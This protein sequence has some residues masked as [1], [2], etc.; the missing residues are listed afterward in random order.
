MNRSERGF[1][2]ILV[3][4]SLVLL[5]S[6]ATGFSLAV[7]HQTRLAADL[8]A[9]ARAEAAA[10]AAL[11]TAMLAVAAT[12]GEARWR[13]DGRE[14]EIPWPDAKITVRVQSESGRIDINTA[15]PEL[16][17]GL[18]TRLFP[19]SDSAALTDALLDWRDHDDHPRDNGAEDRAYKEAGYAY[20][21]S[22]TPFYSVNELSQVMGFDGE[23][24]EALQ[25]HLTVHSRR[26]RINAAS[27]DLVVLSSIPGID[28]ATAEAFIEHREEALAGDGEIDYSL[29]RSGRRFLDRRRD[30]RLFALDIEVRLDDGL[31]RREHAVLRLD[32]RRGYTLLARETRPLDRTQAGNIR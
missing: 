28:A 13:A 22:N 24:L 21:P 19:T 23:K 31:T 20:G 12:G 6:L 1:A 8:S 2:L 14:H 30:N 26:P 16:L 29:L 9:V 7:R 32:R 11:H 25:P 15:P 3:V 5:A 18:F 4:W 27:A 17:S 10:T